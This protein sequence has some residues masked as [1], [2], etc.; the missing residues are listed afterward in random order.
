MKPAEWKKKFGEVARGWRTS[1]EMEYFYGLKVTPARAKLYL[2]Q[3]GLYVRNRRSLWMQIGAN[4][5]VME[6][7]Q[8]I[9]EHEY[10]EMI[11]DDYSPTGHLDLVLR[12]G[13]ELGLTTEEIMAAEPLPSTRAAIYGWF[14][15]ARYRPW[16]EALAASTSSEGMNDDRLLGDLGG[17]NTTTLTKTWARDLGL[18][19]EQMPHF[20]AHSKADEKHSDMFLEILEKYVPAGK[21]AGVL[22]AVQESFDLMRAYFGGMAVVLSRLS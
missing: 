13:K 11:R 8:D 17:G 15:N 19:P 20:T 12:Q 21:E 14:W 22:E 6:V 18:K 9:L 4:C 1:P 3:L 5:P 7:K 10:E 2:L 16:Y